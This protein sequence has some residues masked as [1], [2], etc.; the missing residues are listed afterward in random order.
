[1]IEHSREAR[2][3]VGHPKADEQEFIQVPKK[4]FEDFRSYVINDIAYYSWVL[5][6][7]PE[8]VLKNPHFVETIVNHLLDLPN[9]PH[10]R[11]VE[12]R[13]AAQIRLALL[14]G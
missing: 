7:P 2:E 8:L 11:T 1:M 9:K 13:Q 6:V 3:A 10:S 12:G 5:G 4:L 14:H